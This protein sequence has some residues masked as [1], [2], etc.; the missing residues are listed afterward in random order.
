MLISVAHSLEVQNWASM[1]ISAS[2]HWVKG[3]S[4]P[5]QAWA[6]SQQV[7]KLPLGDFP[8]CYKSEGRRRKNCGRG[9]ALG[10]KTAQTT[11]EEL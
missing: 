6:E 8:N 3:Q 4:C 10:K 5:A 7:H 2:G 1:Q 11:T 9:G